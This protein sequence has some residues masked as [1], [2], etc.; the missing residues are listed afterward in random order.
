MSQPAAFSPVP[1]QAVGWENKPLSTWSVD[2]A[3]DWLE[4]AMRQRIELVLDEGEVLFIPACCAHEISGEALLDDGTPA[5][6]V[7]SMNRFWRTRSSLVRPHLAPEA[8]TS[9][10]ASL[11]FE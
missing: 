9:Y 10:N 11:A 8:L 5:E 7:L 1:K 4:G 2:E 6:H 3:A